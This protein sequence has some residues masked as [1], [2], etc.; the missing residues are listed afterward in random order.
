MKIAMKIEKSNNPA[1][2]GALVL[3]LLLII[4]RILWMIFGHSGLA[5]AASTVSAGA[6]AP[7]SLPASVTQ[8]TPAAVASPP[9]EGGLVSS[10]TPVSTRN[11]F[12]VATRP[13]L[14]VNG[15]D[16]L[17]RPDVLPHRAATGAAV[18]PL[19]S[20]PPLPVRFL[21][22]SPGTGAKQPSA[23]HGPGALSPAQIKANGQMETL[24]ALKLTA[25]VGGMEPQAVVQTANPEPVILRVGDTLDGMRVAAIHEQKVVFTRGNGVWTLSLQSATDSAAS[26][27]SVTSVAAPEETTDG[28]Q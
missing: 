5:A 10:A 2:V 13:A 11:P 1:A 12:A 8:A 14:P 17:P 3:V 20:L 18:M 9:P 7:S 22:G 21:P 23:A 19:M 26:S 16:G 4:G 24:A 28:L 6:P 15:P 27:A 25:T